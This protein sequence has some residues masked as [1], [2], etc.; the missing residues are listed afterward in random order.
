MSDKTSRLDVIKMII[1]HQAIC[2]QEELLREMDKAGFPVTQATLSRDLR[3]LK[4]SK[5]STPSGKYVYVL[6][7]SPHYRR[8]PEP[9]YQSTLRSWGVKSVKFSGQ[10]AVIHTLPGHAS[11]IAYE[12]DNKAMEEVIGTIAGDD[13]IML[14]MAEGVGREQL[15][16]RLSAVV[17]EITL[18]LEDV[19]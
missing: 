2:N 17:P 8:V 5:S 18:A 19:R 15:I 7:S 3:Q 9:V 14:V 1:S 11:P 10:L 6:P 12:I 16:S 13:T 4:V